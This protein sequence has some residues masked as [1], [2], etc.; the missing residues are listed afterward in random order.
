M[1]SADEST[2]DSVA[3]PAP[4]PVAWLPDTV[5]P[6]ADAVK[7]VVEYVGDSATGALS[8]LDDL[9]AG[10]PGAFTFRKGQHRDASFGGTVS[11]TPSEITVDWEFTTAYDT[12]RTKFGVW[13]G[14]SGWTGQP[15]LV[16]WPD[17]CAQRFRAGAL[18]N[19]SFAGREIIVGSLCGNVY[20]LNPESGAPTRTP[21]NAGNPIKGTVSLDPTLN[22][23][24]YVGQ[25]IPANKPFG[26]VVVDLYKNAVSHV[27][28]EDAKAWR[29][30]GAY[31]S[32]PV[33]VGQ[34]L[35]RP[36]ENG[37][38]YK[39]NVGSGSLT[40]H[41]VLRYRVAGSAPGIEASM[42]VWRNYGFVC[43]NHGNII[44][45]NLD[46]MRPVWHYT[47]G[48]DIDSTPA[49]CVEDGK[50]YIYTG[51]EID[52]QGS[53]TAKY[54]KLNALNG[55][56]VWNTEIEGNRADV[57]GKHF[58]GGYYASALPGTGN[59][60]HLIYNNCVLNTDSMQNGIFVAF[61]RS[62]GRIAYKTPLKYYAWSSPVGY[63]NE[64]GEMF[65]LTLDAAGRAY[66]INGADGSI[67][68]V[69]QV[70]ANFE[71][72]PVV[73]DNHAVVG[74]RGRSIYRMSIQ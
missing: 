47:L 9:Y 22:G 50:A 33:R 70:G 74:S 23:N 55:E 35:F 20:F 38:V 64:K 41:S 36:G 14:G 24:L 67:I 39:F 71:S 21:I 48:D 18:V 10:T 31:D 44:A 68:T 17:S 29:G 30:W 16:D 26:A 32:S 19:D 54:V 45:F 60:S 46:N 62:T 66:L 73:W 40:L 1:G 7:F 28:P 11:G 63:L 12:T 15:L 43:D 59:C 34:F 65:I 6:S 53:G 52:R 2:A 25:G 13:G 51:C 61:E 27:F 58:D 42:A 57:G 5:Y 37:S 4:E 72:S 49:L 3:V 69:K 8:S 56:A